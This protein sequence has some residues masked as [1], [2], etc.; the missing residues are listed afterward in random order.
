MLIENQI[1]R[2]DHTH[3]GQI[4]TYAAGLQAAVIV[5]VSARF[6]DEH[7]AALDWLNTVTQDGFAFFGVEVELWRI[8]VSPACTSLQ[9]CEQAQYLEPRGCEK[10]AASRAR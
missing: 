3:L 7:R 8:G 5:W 10:C 1:E 9:C 4:L 2:T 6:T